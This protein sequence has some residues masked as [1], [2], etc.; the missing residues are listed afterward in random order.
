MFTNFSLWPQ[1]TARFAQAAQAVGADDDVVD[2]VNTHQLTGF[3]E[4]ARHIDIFV[5]RCERTSRMIVRD[6]DRMRVSQQSGFEYLTR[7]NQARRHG[8]VRNNVVSDDLI[9]RVKVE[10]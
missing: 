4:C 9:F 3:D 2:H 8:A 7:V 6:D 10:S 1:V 5:A